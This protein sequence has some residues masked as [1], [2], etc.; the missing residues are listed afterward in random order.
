MFNI[1]VVGVVHLLRINYIEPF[2]MLATILRWL[3]IG[4]GA[5]TFLRLLFYSMEK[6]A[7]IPF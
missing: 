4:T 6:S 7:Q 3:F 1:E 5:S 2:V